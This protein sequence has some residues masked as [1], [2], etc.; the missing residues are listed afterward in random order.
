MTTKSLTNPIRV[1][2]VDGHNAC[3][4]ATKELLTREGFL[5]TSEYSGL[6]AYGEIMT[7]G[8]LD[9]FDVA[10]I[11]YSVMPEGFKVGDHLVTGLDLINFLADIHYDGPTIISTSTFSRD[12]RD[13]AT[14]YLR[15]PIKPVELI[16]AVRH[17][18]LLNRHRT[19]ISEAICDAALESLAEQRGQSPDH[20]R[21]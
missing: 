4:D 14:I 17:M 11:D 8:S 15:K 10:L 5:V 9:G 12:S 3:L 18:G 13:R 19:F 7:P 6:R 1:W 21:Q 20:Y 2:H 16:P